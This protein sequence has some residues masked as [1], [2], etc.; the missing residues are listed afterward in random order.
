M[1]MTLMQRLF[2]ELNIIGFDIVEIDRYGRCHWLKNA[3]DYI[4]YD[5]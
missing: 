1:A 3:F 5:T 2:R 4:G